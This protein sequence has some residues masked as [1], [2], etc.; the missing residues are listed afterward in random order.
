MRQ[1]YHKGIRATQIEEGKA[2]RILLPS[3]SMSFIGTDKELNK[4]IDEVGNIFMVN[5]KDRE[6]PGWE[7]YA[8]DACQCIVD[9]SLY[10]TG[11]DEEKNPTLKRA[12]TMAGKAMELWRKE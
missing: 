10:W 1:I 3:K 4:F 2:W 8:M 6:L 5:I 7:T 9:A 11:E 12:R